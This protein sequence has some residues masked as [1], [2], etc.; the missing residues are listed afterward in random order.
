[1]T[2]TSLINCLQSHS[3][4]FFPE[5]WGLEACDE[6]QWLG[7]INCKV[8]E[9]HRY[10]IAQSTDLEIN[11]RNMCNNS[12]C[13]KK[14]RDDNLNV[15]QEDRDRVTA[16]PLAGVC[17]CWCALKNQCRTISSISWNSHTGVAVK[18]NRPY[19]KTS[20]IYTICKTFFQG[21]RIIDKL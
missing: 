4:S 12:F 19:L 5:L 21:L 2:Y 15:H 3:I 11:L 10:Q 16:W 18:L 13:F 1:M 8:K 17:T 7:H 14:R 9:T 6:C 20:N